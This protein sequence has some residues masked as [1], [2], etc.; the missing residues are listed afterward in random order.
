MTIDFTKLTH[1]LND[2]LALGIP[3]V[4]CIVKRG[5]DTIYR[6]QAGFSDRER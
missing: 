5:Y 1:F 4:D 2:L 6:H 3:G